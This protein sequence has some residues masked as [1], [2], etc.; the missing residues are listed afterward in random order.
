[1][2]RLSIAMQMKSKPIVKLLIKEGLD[3][4]AV[5]EGGDAPIHIASKKG[6]IQTFLQLLLDAGADINHQDGAGRTPI[7]NLLGGSDTPKGSS[8][9]LKNGSR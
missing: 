9:R 3:V 1:M 7:L 8:R 6:S 5:D 4:N 2:N